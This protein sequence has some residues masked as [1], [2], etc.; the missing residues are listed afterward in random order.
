[1]KDHIEIERLFKDDKKVHYDFSQ[2]PALIELH[3]KNTDQTFEKDHAAKW[4]K[5]QNEFLR[6]T[7]DRKVFPKRQVE[8]GKKIFDEYFKKRGYLQGNIL[9]VGGGWGLFR[10]WW[11]ERESNIF[12]VHDP[13]IERF[14]RGP[15]KLHHDYYKRAFSLPMTFVEGFGEDLPYKDGIFD[16][17]LIAAT[18]DHCIWPQEIIRAAYR[19]IRPDGIILI[20]QRCGPSGP[21]GDFVNI[22]RRLKAYLFKPER[23][24][25]AF[26]RRLFYRDP[27]LHHFSIQGITALLEEAGFSK[28]RIEVISMAENIY[29]F[30]AQK[31]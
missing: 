18:L 28:V 6:W 14:L 4:K 5:A 30:E 17:Y 9:D 7:K 11:E 23:F 13:G 8:D 20:I 3:K 27:H 24:L 21:L 22:F 15:H 16:L 31:R 2:S 29:A 25:R 12:I 1:M 10:E 26:Y 19:C